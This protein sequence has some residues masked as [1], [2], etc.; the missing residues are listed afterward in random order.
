MERPDTPERQRESLKAMLFFP[1]GGT[2]DNFTR[3]EVP[4]GYHTIGVFG[5]FEDA[6]RAIE[7]NP[8]NV[9]QE[10]VDRFGVRY[11][12]RLDM[13][14]VYDETTTPEELAAEIERKSKLYEVPRQYEIA[15]IVPG[16]FGFNEK[17]IA[18]VAEYY[19]VSGVPF[20]AVDSLGDKAKTSELLSEIGFPIPQERVCEGGAEERT[21]KIMSAT[22]EI[23]LP[24]IM[25]PIDGAGSIGCVDDDPTLPE[26][27]RRKRAGRHVLEIIRYQKKFAKA[28]LS[29]TLV[30][31]RLDGDEVGAQVIINHGQLFSFYTRKE[32]YKNKERGHYFDSNDPIH[33]WCQT[34]ISPYLPRLIGRLGVNSWFLNGDIKLPNDWREMPINPMYPTLIDV[35]SPTPEDTPKFFPL[36]LQARPGGDGLAVLQSVLHNKNMGR[37]MIDIARGKDVRHELVPLRPRSAGAIEVGFPD[38]GEVLW[39]PLQK[40][41]AEHVEKADTGKGFIHANVLGFTEARHIPPLTS[42]FNSR[43]HP[44]VGFVGPDAA[45]VRQRLDS[46]FASFQTTLWTNGGIDLYL[47]DKGLVQVRDQH[48]EGFDQQQAYDVLDELNTTQDAS[49]VTLWKKTYEK[50][51]L[52]MIPLKRSE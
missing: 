45:T 48:G 46:A 42:F 43:E 31:E 20:T 17:F 52:K 27:E 12:D 4:E 7:Q 30:Q 15:G 39:P 21:A 51:K 5:L 1:T 16:V 23:G 24:T 49:M 33:E 36:D 32:M 8:D 34:Y 14:I 37:I 10:F 19:G 25:K 11:G 41:F 13:L 28:A 9:Q 50:G 40:K 22:D 47:P 35:N 2:Q 44:V 29:P 26:E 38:G 18:E 3:S 6:W